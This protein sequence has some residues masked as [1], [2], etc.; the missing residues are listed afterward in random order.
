MLL[1]ITVPMAILGTAAVGLFWGI[2]RISRPAA[3]LF[4]D[5]FPDVPDHPDVSDPGPR[6]SAAV[7]PTFFFLAA[8]AGWGAVWL[9]DLVSRTHPRVGQCDTT[10]RGEPGPRLGGAGTDSHPPVR[11][12]AIT[13]S[14]PAARAGRGGGF[15]LTYWYDAFTPRVIEDLNWRFPPHAQVDFLNK[16]TNTASRFSRTSLAWGS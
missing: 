16:K 4:S 11:A 5:P 1:A 12:L 3:A 14:W 2:A 7:P 13:T 15:E 8:F 6:R 9:A 10:G